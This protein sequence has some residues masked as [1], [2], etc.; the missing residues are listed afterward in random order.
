[1]LPCGWN[2]L[3][4]RLMKFSGRLLLGAVCLLV[5]EGIS[6]ATLLAWEGEVLKGTIPVKTL[7]TTVSN[8]NPQVIDVGAL[9]GEQQNTWVGRRRSKEHLTGLMSRKRDPRIA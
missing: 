8:G 2:T 4:A 7:F 6:R 9:T 3:H 1:M 5:G